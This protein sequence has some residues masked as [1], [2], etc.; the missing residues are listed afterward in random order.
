MSA[1]EADRADAVAA[2]EGHREACP[3]FRLG[4]GGAGCADCASLTGHVER[5]ERQIALLSAPGETAEMF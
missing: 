5:T 1:A 3:N 2:R 4:Y